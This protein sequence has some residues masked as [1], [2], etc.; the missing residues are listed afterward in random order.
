MLLSFLL[1]LMEKSFNC[2]TQ[3]LLRLWLTFALPLLHRFPEELF[4]FSYR[5]PDMGRLSG[6]SHVQCLP[7][8]AI[9]TWLFALS[10]LPFFSMSATS[11]VELVYQGHLRT[12]MVPH[13]TGMVS[14]NI[15]DYEMRRKVESI[16]SMPIGSIDQLTSFATKE[17]CGGTSASCST[18][19]N[20]YRERLG[21]K[22]L[23]LSRESD[24]WTLGC[25]FRW[26]VEC[27]AVW[28]KPRFS[29]LKIYKVA[30]EDCIATV[31]GRQV[32][33]QQDVLIDRL[34]VTFFFQCSKMLTGKT[35]LGNDS[36]IFLDSE[37]QLHL[38]SNG[39]MSL[40]NNQWYVNHHLTLEKKADKAF[41]FSSVFDYHYEPTHPVELT[42]FIRGSLSGL[43]TVVADADLSVLNNL[44]RTPTCVTDVPINPVYV[45]DAVDGTSGMGFKMNKASLTCSVQCSWSNQSPTLIYCIHGFC[46]VPTDA[47]RCYITKGGSR[48]SQS[49]VGITLEGDH[50]QR[51]AKDDAVEVDRGEGSSDFVTT[52]YKVF[53]K[54]SSLLLTLGMMAGVIYLLGSTQPLFAIGFA[55][56][57]WFYRPT[58]A[59]PYEGEVLLTALSV[60]TLVI[61]STTEPNG[62]GQLFAI[63]MVYRLIVKGQKN[64]LPYLV[65][66]LYAL[67]L[68]LAGCSLMYLLVVHFDQCSLILDYMQE[69]LEP[70][71]CTGRIDDMYTFK[72]YLSLSEFGRHL[73]RIQ[74]WYRKS[75]YYAGRLFK[76]KSHRIEAKAVKLSLYWGNPLKAIRTKVLQSVYH[77]N[78]PMRRRQEIVRNRNV[79]NMRNLFFFESEYDL[80]QSVLVKLTPSE[81]YEIYNRKVAICGREPFELDFLNHLKWRSS[82]YKE[83]GELLMSEY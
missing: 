19:L 17:V 73:S 70:Y 34:R 7:T 64:F 82:L 62:L 36:H 8:R 48:P 58:F 29:T 46:K 15:T 20:D 24:T 53:D 83:I 21:V 6:L 68:P 1:K 55:I 37:Y 25:A 78:Y 27:I 54:G 76:Q 43:M 40:E 45:T 30:S 38:M 51:F 44:E 47:T 41:T 26:Y 32:T 65:A 14:I 3:S 71:M 59:T 23:F 81:I 60:P 74:S 50:R 28:A 63:F 39:Y 80:F 4:T 35:F 12:V 2:F 33:N 42:Q 72:E 57:I 16:G 49:W 67:N 10:L 13:L 11:S 56:L 61:Q 52:V 79:R 77:D 31:N 5:L 69:G 22:P 66:L 75:T 9:K 18:D